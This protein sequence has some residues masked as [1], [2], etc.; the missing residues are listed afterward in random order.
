MILLK[1]VQTTV[2]IRFGLMS[3]I[4]KIKIFTFFIKIAIDFVIIESFILSFNR[5]IIA[6][7]HLV[8]IM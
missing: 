4:L 1:K 7:R 5:M 3:F 8:Y 2:G 6:L